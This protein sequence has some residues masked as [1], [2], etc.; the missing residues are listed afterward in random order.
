[1]GE[2]INFYGSVLCLSACVLFIAVYSVMPFVTGRRRW[3]S[4][5][6]GRMMVTKA[7]A[8]AGLMLI[9]VVFY[10]TDADAEW[11]RGIRGVFAAVIAVMMTYQSW[12]V[13]RLMTQKEDQRT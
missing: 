5:R 12:L 11:I 6:I 1:M 3:W 4:S 8:L 2:K 7:L 13:Y 10:L 9:V